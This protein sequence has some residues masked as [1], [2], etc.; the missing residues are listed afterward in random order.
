MHSDSDKIEVMIN[1][2]ADEVTEEFFKSLQNRYQNNLEEL[3]K[4]SNFVFNYVDLLYNGNHKLNFKRVKSHT[5][6]PN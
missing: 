6:C 2:R 5:D 1:D 3:M 4:D